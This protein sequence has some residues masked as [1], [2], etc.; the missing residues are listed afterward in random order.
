MCCLNYLICVTVIDCFSFHFIVEP[1][2]W[3]KKY[4]SEKER[5]QKL[6]EELSLLKSELSASQKKLLKSFEQKG[7]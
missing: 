3:E 6:E 2:I 5:A 1:S 4:I 7:S